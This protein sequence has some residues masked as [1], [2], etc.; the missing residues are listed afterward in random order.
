[1]RLC[2]SRILVMLLVASLGG[3]CTGAPSPNS[4]TAL[5]PP[6]Q[7]AA[8]RT[9]P[10]VPGRPARVFVFAGWDTNCAALAAPHVTVTTPPNQGEIT[11]RAG[12]QTT[13]AASTGGTCNGRAVAGTGVYY[14]AREGAAGEDRFAVEARL[15]SGETNKRTFAVTIAP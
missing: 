6:T 14:T 3:G 5:E 13:I 7:D 15:A 11:F 2:R 12:Q 9:M 10:V 1:M 4:G 8:T